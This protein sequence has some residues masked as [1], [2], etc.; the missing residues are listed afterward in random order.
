VAGS[1]LR[2]KSGALDD[3]RRRPA[4]AASGVLDCRPKRGRKATAARQKGARFRPWRGA[5]ATSNRKAGLGVCENS[6]NLLPLSPSLSS[7]S[8]GRRRWGHDTRATD[9]DAIS[10]AAQ[11]PSLVFER[12][13]KAD[14]LRTP[15]FRVRAA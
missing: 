11:R 3:G 9:D 15:R 13:N 4:A 10:I 7:P 12:T 14:A 6:S 8:V 2:S 1:G 5:F